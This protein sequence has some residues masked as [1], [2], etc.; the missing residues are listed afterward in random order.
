MFYDILFLLLINLVLQHFLRTKVDVMVSARPESSLCYASRMKRFCSG[1]VV[2]SV[3]TSH[4]DLVCQ[5]N[6]RVGSNFLTSLEERIFFICPTTCIH[7]FTGLVR[8]HRKF[9]PVRYSA[10]FRGRLADVVALCVTD[11]FG[12]LPPIHFR[13]T[14]KEVLT[15]MGKN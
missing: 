15:V 13:H 5:V 6:Y 8:V 11:L 12:P 7:S 2:E 3:C 10:S 4:D 1:S 9:F 14:T